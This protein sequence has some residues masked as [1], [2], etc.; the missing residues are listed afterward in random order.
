M[1][2]SVLGCGWLGFP[3]AQRLL[4]HH[5]EIN[6]ST[7]TQKKI[8]LLR[9]NG[10]NPYLI[11]LPD[12]LSD[13]SVENFWNS[14]LYIINIPPGRKN[15]NVE[16]DF[17]EVIDQ[18]LRKG[19]VNSVSWI[20]FASSTSVYNNLSG[21]TTEDDAAPGKASSATGEA[22][23]SSE[24]LIRGSGINYTIL[25]LGGL[26]GYGRHPVKYLSGKKRLNGA[27][28]AVNL[29]HQVD[30]VNI[31]EEVITQKKKNEIYNLVSD[32]HPP[33]KELYQSAAEH[34]G[35]PLPEF[36]PNEDKNYKIVSNKKIKQD[37]QYRFIYPNPMDHTP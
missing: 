25:R 31:I 23:L 26:Y 30:C 15:K 32:G 4:S 18:I 35:L 21:V 8:S 27:S 17:P 28:K 7:T 36:L 6:G 3:L 5:D 13:T 34:F 19:K 37:L 14:D 11:N 20:I 10:I 12:S 2:I 33:R 1:K 22:L 29:I 16:N 9:Q 24:K